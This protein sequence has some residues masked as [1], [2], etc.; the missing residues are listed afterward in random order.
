MM[1]WE[2]LSVVLCYCHSVNNSV[3]VY[4]LSYTAPKCCSSHSAGAHLQTLSRNFSLLLVLVY[5]TDSSVGACCT[6][7]AHVSTSSER[8]H[9]IGQRE[10]RKGPIRLPRL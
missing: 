4:E 10:P 6:Q 7:T 1:G 9:E 3:T 5:S 2:P 8:H